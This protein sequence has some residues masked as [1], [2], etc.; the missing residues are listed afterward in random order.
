[1]MMILQLASPRILQ[2][3]CN[4]ESLASIFRPPSITESGPLSIGV[5]QRNASKPGGMFEAQTTS[6]KPDQ[7]S[8]TPASMAHV[9]AFGRTGAR[10]Q[11]G[12]SASAAPTC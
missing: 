6:Q 9:L 7:N 10:S 11:P 8:S 3:P 1:M 5:D 2:V 12:T 4:T